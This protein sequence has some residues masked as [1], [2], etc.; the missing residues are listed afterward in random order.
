MYNSPSELQ[1]KVARESAVAELRSES[2]SELTGLLI[3]SEITMKMA[4][5][6]PA[7]TEKLSRVLDSAKRI[8]ATLEK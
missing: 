1:Y 8:R 2:K 4:N 6:P 7:V 3:C 5:L